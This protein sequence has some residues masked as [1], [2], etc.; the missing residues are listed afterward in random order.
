[1]EQTKL[2]KIPRPDSDLPSTDKP[3]IRPTVERMMSS[4]T[5]DS[6]GRSIDFDNTVL[7]NMGEGMYTVDVN[8]CVTSMNHTAEILFQRTFDEAIGLKMHDLTHSAKRDGTAFPAK[9]CAEFGVLRNG[10]TV[11][12]YEDV[13]IRKDGTFF[14]VIYSSSPIREDGAIN[15]LVVVFRDVSEQNR[16]LAALRESEERFEKAFNASP[17]ALMIASV[18]TGKLIEVNDTFVEMFGYLQEQV[19]G[20]TTAEFGLWV[21]PDERTAATQSYLD[22][23]QIRNAEHRFRTRSG[24]EIIGL[25]SADRIEAGGEICV[26]AVIQNITERRFAEMQI[27]L[28]NEILTTLALGKSL[29]DILD[30]ITLTLERQLPGCMASVLLISE[31]G[32]RLVHGSAP[33]L[34]PAYSA[35]IEGVAIGPQ[36]SSCGTAA[37]LKEPVYVSDIGSDPRWKDFAGLAAEHNLKACWST[38]ILS[39]TGS[40]LGTLALYYSQVR[41]PNA[42]YLSLIEITTRTAALAIERKNAECERQLL[43][44]IVENSI[45][46]IG[47]A[48][49]V[50]NPVY[51]NP[52]G[53]KLVGLDDLDQVRESAIPDY[54]IP[55]EQPLISDVVI[56]T[57]LRDGKWSGELTFQHFKTG[58][59]IPVLS[60]VFSVN[61]PVTGNTVNFA[62]VIRDISNR[63]EAEKAI[64]YSEER[65][66]TAVAAVSDLIWT[67]SPDG[68]MEGEQ[69][70]WESFTGQTY[71]EYQ[72]Y[73]WAQAVHADDAPATLKAWNQAVAEK[74]TFI[75]EH[76]VRRRDG[77]WRLCS[78]RAVP[79]LETDGTIREWVGVHSDIT[80]Q[81]RAEENLKAADE[82]F[83]RAQMAGKVG[84]WDWDKTTGKT[85]WSETMWDLYGEKRREVNP[86][87]AF[88][89]KRIDERDRERVIARLRS[90][91]ESGAEEYRDEFRTVPI[92][93]AVRWI[94]SIGTVERDAAGRPVRMYGV[95]LDIT[96]KKATEDRIL[97]SENELRVITDSVPALISYIDRDGRY[98]F[99]NRR[100]SEFFGMATDEIIG[101]TISELLG[102][103]VFRTLEPNVK[104]VLAGERCSIEVQVDYK[105]AGRRFMQFS[106]VPDFSG[107]GDVPG[108]YALVSDLTEKMQYEEE[109]QRANDELEARVVDRTQELAEANVLLLHQMDERALVA[110]QRT[111]LLRRLFT[112]QEDER[113]RIA[114]DI[115]DQLGQSL[116]ALR[117]KIASLGDLCPDDPAVTERINR[118]QEV[119]EQLDSEVSFVAWDLRPSVLDD[120]EFVKALENYVSEW[121]RRSDIF[122]EFDAIGLSD[123][124]LDEDIENNL[125]RIT[126]EALN[127]AAKH[128]KADRINVVLEKRGEHLMLIIE[129]NG[130]GFEPGNVD[131]EPGKKGG[132][133]LFGMRERASLVSGTIEIES[134]PKKGTSIFVRV[135]LV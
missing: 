74:T 43:A 41:K 39:A 25:L 44:S 71:D 5:S 54:F 87:E 103:N 96:D 92:D 26:L 24:E 86:D 114:R 40:V 32:Q 90:T 106:Y 3:V 119:A 31:D 37:Y 15:G 9:E 34:A 93:G 94:E 63:K 46:Y 4:R 59:P 84:V 60:D 2:R 17:M 27:A 88:W 116:T 21:N 128:A 80:E 115:H 1:M 67:N 49:A 36:V 18:E 64:R 33:S 125:Y 120:V 91:F 101:K 58:A 131:P 78:I 73:G 132:F 70:G 53:M 100:Y 95:N 121:S 77:E 28:Q 72:G 20:K 85:Y 89:S 130:A 126:Q 83:R 8:G 14:D 56:P 51:V 113:G 45:D 81:K 68:L 16:T 105:V 10:K 112:M 129:D 66:R 123:V 76:R 122:T 111:R 133:G 52:A 61:D 38:P 109:L 69:P 79:I 19:V 98:R 29:P 127:N 108:F 102:A 110:E 57:A 42:Q 12:N 13:F 124:T 65:F 48:D 11:K 35:A 30:A 62:A 23:G 134:S 99:V 55:D 7:M 22:T 135:P 75:F 107:E 118:L 50:G 117:L 97:R 47:I 6:R 82:R 104:K